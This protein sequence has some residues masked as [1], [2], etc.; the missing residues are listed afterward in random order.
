MTRDSTSWFIVVAAYLSAALVPLTIM[1]SLS[2]GYST[3]FLGLWV[4]PDAKP[5]RQ[6][7]SMTA[8]SALALTGIFSMLGL[9]PGPL[10]PR[11][12]AAIPAAF[13]LT[14]TGLLLY[15]TLRP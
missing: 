2:S 15:L 9:I 3:P 10:W 14:T 1:L 12:L 7:M 13:F 8:M 6:A 5:F 4:P 11:V